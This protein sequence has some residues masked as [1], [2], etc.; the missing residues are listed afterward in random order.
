MAVPEPRRVMWDL[1]WTKHR[2][3]CSL[4]TCPSFHQLLHTDLHPSSGAVTLA[5]T[6]ANMAQ[7]HPIQKKT[8]VTFGPQANY[9]DSATATCWRNLVPTFADR[10]VLRGQR[11][12]SST[13]VNLSFLDRSRYFF[14]QVAPH[15]SS[16]RL[17]GPRSRPNATQKIWHRR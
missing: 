16:Q 14:F 5:Q 1:W 12:G 6:V 2:G 17:S 11:G 4:S 13:V 7:S 3:K 8:S 10:G 15:L 9:I